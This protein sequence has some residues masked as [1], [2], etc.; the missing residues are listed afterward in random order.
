MVQTRELVAFKLLARSA[1]AQSHTGDTAEFVFA[2]ITIPA[3]SLG[4]NGILR[5]ST[6]W[7][8]TNSANAKTGRI[9]LGGAAGTQFLSVAHT[10]S[11]A[12]SDTRSIANRNA[13][14]SQVGIGAGTTVSG[15]TSTAA[16]TTSSVDTSLAQDLVLSGQLANS[17]ET[18]TLERYVVEVTE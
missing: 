5:I 1:V 11:A 12:F 9:R 6:Y 16:P 14:N 10:T 13:L 18:I 17:G 15:G 4:V 8:Y 3:G 7:S 2:T